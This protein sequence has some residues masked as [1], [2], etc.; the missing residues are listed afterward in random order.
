[1]S[2]KTN[3]KNK[4]L[5]KI[6]LEKLIS[7]TKEARNFTDLARKLNI[8]TSSSC[9]KIL[10]EFIKEKNICVKHFVKNSGIF[11]TPKSLSEILIKNSTYCS[12]T[13]KKRLLKQNILKNECYECGLL[14]IW[15]NKPIKL[16]IDHINGD[17]Y[18]NRLEN[19]RILCPN[20]H[21]QT[22]TYGSKQRRIKTFCSDCGIALK[23]KRK[24]CKDCHTIKRKKFQPTNKKF[25]LPKEELEQLVWKISTCEIARQYN[26]SD[27]A[28]AKRCKRLNI[29]K[30]PRGYWKKLQAQNSL[31]VH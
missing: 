21:T 13:L 25:N 22:D 9:V 7:I 12:S 10:K 1:M 15:N 6:N 4:I 19:L 3:N 14:P 16:Q 11:L 5:D 31:I 30:P 2:K 27:T 17:H 8:T 20:C 18:D 24:L 28:V 23:T 29:N 26:V